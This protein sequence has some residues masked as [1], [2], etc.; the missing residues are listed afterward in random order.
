MKSRYLLF[1]ASIILLL[2]QFSFG[3]ENHFTPFSIN[4]QKTNSFS[5]NV[6]QK[7]IPVLVLDVN[8][9]EMLLLK[10]STS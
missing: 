1:T 6:N 10:N 2:A 5:V 3:L 9:S 8:T 7:E 4:A